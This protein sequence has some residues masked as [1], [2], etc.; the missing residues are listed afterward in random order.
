MKT[1]IKCKENK[2]LDSFY[3]RKDNKEGFRNSCKMCHSKKTNEWTK[4][5]PEKKR[6]SRKLWKLN[7][8]EKT[9]DN[10]LKLEYGITLD[11]KKKMYSDQSGCCGICKKEMVNLKVSYVDHNHQTGQ[12]RKLLCPPCNT[13]LGAIKENFDSALNL[14]KYIQEHNGTI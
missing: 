14:A 8:P 7:N 3:P 11:E 5:N 10:W 1:C 12:V 13:Y 2:S 4:N 9:Q 6:L